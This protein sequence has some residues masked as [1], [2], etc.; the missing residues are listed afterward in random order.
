MILKSFP[1]DSDSK[2]SACN[3][4]NLGSIPGLRRSPGGGNRYPLQY[5]GLKNSIDYIVQGIA[6]SQAQLSN[7]HLALSNIESIYP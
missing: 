3:V 4:K 7:F 2:E 1:D 5:S 6:K